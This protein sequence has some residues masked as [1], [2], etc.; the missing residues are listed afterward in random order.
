MFTK[1][2]PLVVLASAALVAGSALDIGGPAGPGQAATGRSGPAIPDHNPPDTCDYPGS[3]CVWGQLWDTT[4]GQLPGEKA[5]H[6]GPIDACC[7]CDTTCSSP[8]QTVCELHG[9]HGRSGAE[10]SYF[11]VLATNQSWRIKPRVAGSHLSWS[12]A[13]RVVSKGV[14]EG[15]INIF[16]F[17]LLGTAPT[18][19]IC[20]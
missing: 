15:S 6:E 12:P 7:F 11:F 10:G 16:N 3:S 4:A 8:V 5:L 17:A 19:D 13:E 20:D 1:M 2:I 14:A 18:T 9:P